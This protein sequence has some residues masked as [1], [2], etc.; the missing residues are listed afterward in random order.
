MIRNHPSQPAFTGGEMSPLILG[1]HDL[2][3]FLLGGQRVI[4]FIA[5]HQGPL[6]RRRGTQWIRSSDCAGGRLVNFERTCSDAEMLQI[7]C[8]EI[9]V[10]ATIPGTPPLPVIAEFSQYDLEDAPPFP[11]HAFKQTNE[12][13]E[14]LFFLSAYVSGSMTVKLSITPNNPARSAQCAINTDTLF[15]HVYGIAEY[16]FDGGY[17]MF[18]DDATP[19]DPDTGDPLGSGGLHMQVVRKGRIGA[20][21]N[22]AATPG[23]TTD[24]YGDTW[25]G[26]M[27]QT[28][29]PFA[30]QGPLEYWL[31]DQFVQKFYSRDT[32]GY[33]VGGDITTFQ[34]CPGMEVD[35]RFT[36]TVTLETMGVEVARTGTPARTQELTGY[37][38]GT[39]VFTGTKSKVTFTVF[40]DPAKSKLS[41]TLVFTV[42]P[43]SGTPYTLTRIRD[44]DVTGA[45]TVIEVEYPWI[46]DATVTLTSWTFSYILSIYTDFEEYE[47]DPEV[48]ILASSS[49]W[50]HPATFLYPAP[51][52]G[53]WDDFEDGDTSITPLISLTTGY[54]WPTQAGSF[55]TKDGT[56]CEDSFES[57]ATGTTTSAF[58]GGYGWAGLGFLMLVDYR[59]SVD[60][61]ESY[62]VG[63]ITSVTAGTWFDVGLP[64]DGSFILVT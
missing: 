7:G 17:Q 41:S 12:L 24:H 11:P 2:E 43:T 52:P 63:S 38:D 53:H 10:G 4:N 56:L 5:R 8:G 37:D 57:Y 31:D 15:A 29:A 16:T 36:N 44:Y 28:P 62:A 25:N 58:S 42:I 1:R 48:T 61:F 64:I 21:N 45:T 50:N 30:A 20:Y 27:V 40:T 13:G 22:H 32:T 9:L 14:T 49:T 54:G 26:L 34:A 23:T 51:N 19:R 59:P 6:V 46:V 60:S 18:W 39:R 3:R 35:Y 55:I 47:V 33:F